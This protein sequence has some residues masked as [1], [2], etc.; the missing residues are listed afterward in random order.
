MPSAAAAIPIRLRSSLCFRAVSGAARLSPFEYATLAIKPRKPRHRAGKL[1]GA[2]IRT[3]GRSVLNQLPGGDRL[4]RSADYWTQVGLDWADTLGELRGAAMKLGQLASQY[5]DLLPPQLTEQLRKLQ[6]SV[7]PMPFALISPILDAQW[8]P[9]QRAAFV[10]IEPEAIAAASIGQVHRARLADGRAVVV[11]LR[12]PG[13]REAVDSD[14]VH[15]RRLIGLSKVLPL[16][17]PAMDSLMAEVRARLM[18]E[19]DYAAELA[20]LQHQ[21]ARASLPGVLYPEPLPDLCTDGILV[22][23]ETSGLTLEQARELPQATRDA[24]G[25]QMFR[26]IAHQIFT[27]HAVHADPHPGNFAFR[28]DGQFVVYDFGCVKRVP[29]AVIAESRTLL[30]AA[31]QQRWTA[32]HRSLA[33]LGGLSSKA[34]YDELEPMYAEF[35][36]LA[37]TPLCRGERYD[38]SDSAYIDD[39]RAA[40]RRHLKHSFKF[41]PVTELLFVLRALSGLYWN[42]RALGARVPIKAVLA[43]YDIVL[44]NR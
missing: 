42:L 43:K 16:D 15:L 36:E 17:R 19:T 21:R 7:T 1:L 18:E 25:T 5:G 34:R 23:T 4:Q 38:F 30:H 13:V 24:L 32:L 8:T 14:L 2:G 39:L 40:G 10:S 41:K 22:T 44:R 29:E 11:K 9:A 20:H 28:E 6:R 12:Y 27:A 33:A 3:L 31:D 26:W 37:L 35:T